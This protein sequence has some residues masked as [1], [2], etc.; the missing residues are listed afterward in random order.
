MLESQFYS[1]SENLKKKYQN[2]FK[3]Y[4]KN[5]HK[6]YVTASQ[7]IVT[8]K[9]EDETAPTSSIVNGNVI[10]NKNYIS[11]IFNDCFG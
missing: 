6:N 5:V 2:Y 8:L 11:D 4:L 10:T 3:K 1:K 9:S 7:S